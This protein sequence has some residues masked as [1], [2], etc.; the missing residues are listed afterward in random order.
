LAQFIFHK[1]WVVLE[2]FLSVWGSFFDDF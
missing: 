2:L 1:F